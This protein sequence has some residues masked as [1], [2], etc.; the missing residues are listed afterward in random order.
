MFATCLEFL[1]TAESS[2]DPSREKEQL[3]P[4]T[5]QTPKFGYAILKAG[6]G[7]LEIYEIDYSIYKKV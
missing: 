2:L 1:P 4:I 6:Y 3:K 5:S 7:N